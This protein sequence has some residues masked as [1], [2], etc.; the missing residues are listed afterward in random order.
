MCVICSTANILKHGT[1][2]TFL[3]EGLHL[4]ALDHLSLVGTESFL[5]LNL[6]F[7][8]CGSFPI[9]ASLAWD[10]TPG[11]F[12]CHPKEFNF[13]TVTPRFTDPDILLL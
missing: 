11:P 13:F 7:P 8:A 1:L 2:S 6:N 10:S 5:L 3:V 9:Q 4:Q 12:P